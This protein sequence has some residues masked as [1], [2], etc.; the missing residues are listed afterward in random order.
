MA[1]SSLPI[2]ARFQE[3]LERDGCPSAALTLSSGA[4]IGAIPL[5]NISGTGLSGAPAGALNCTTVGASY[6]GA[7]TLLAPATIAANGAGNSLALTGGINNGGNLL[8]IGGSGNVAVNSAGI[9]GAGGLTYSGGGTLTLATASSYQG[10]TTISSGTLRVTNGSGSGT[11]SGNVNIGSSAALN[12]SGTIQG[13]VSIASGATLGGSGTI[14]GTTSVSTGGILAPSGVASIATKT[15]FANLTLSS[16]TV[17][18]FNLA[19]PL[20]TSSGDLLNV[21]GLLN[22]SANGVL[23]INPYGGSS[24]LGSG[25]YP[26]IYFS[27]FTTLDSSNWT[28]YQQPTYTFGFSFGTGPGGSNIFELEVPATT[29]YGTSA[30]SLNSTSGGLYGISNNWVNQTIP[31]GIGQVATFVN[32]NVTGAPR[33]R[34]FESTVPIRSARST[35]LPERLSPWNRPTAARAI[36]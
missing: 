35:S 5:T 27:N 13:D 12:V 21:T 17:L 24:T 19:S 31:N 29:L 1:S 25:N 8:T 11:G 10:T 3:Y 14:Q 30:W 6:A 28:A 22:L 9:S 4:A 18:D 15:N 23:N 36:A 34:R 20:P 32:S 7:I 33:H 26:L 16:G 2:A